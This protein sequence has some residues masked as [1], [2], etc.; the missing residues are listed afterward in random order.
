MDNEKKIGIVF[1]ICFLL[2]LTISIVLM[3]PIYL[4]TSE[5]FQ[6]KQNLQSELDG[7][8]EELTN[9]NSQIYNSKN[10]LI[11]TR[12]SLNITISELEMRKSDGIYE[13]HNPSYSEAMTFVSKDKTDRKK[14]NEE[15]FNCAHYT[16]EVNNNSE[17]EEMRC[18]IVFVDL[19]GGEGHALIAFN[20]TDKGILY[21]EP[22]SDQ[23][24][25]LK[26]GDDYWADCVVVRSSRYYYKR[27]PDNI[28]EDYEIYW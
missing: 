17:I 12:Y 24:V 7:R 5:L 27:D 16:L 28:V 6:E 26:V 21:I 9:L 18:A 8:E 1:G 3:Y 10:E 2:I 23:K 14:Y 20:T 4:S 13:L 22:Q 25:N 11:S 19:S 15:T